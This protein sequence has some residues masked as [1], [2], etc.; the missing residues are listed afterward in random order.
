MAATLRLTR[1]GFGLG[2]RRG[3]FDVALDATNVGSIQWHDTVE[4]PV[5]PGHQTLQMRHGRYSSRTV[6]FDATNGDAVNFNCHGARI[7]PL[8]L[9]SFVKPDLAIA[10]HR[11]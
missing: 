6:S 4:V 9:A 10:L 11:E 5:E 1:E 7:W 3:T 2:L 8:W